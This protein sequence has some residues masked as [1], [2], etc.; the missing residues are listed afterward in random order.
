[1]KTEDHIDAIVAYWH[2]ERPDLD[3]S[4]VEVVG[5]LGRVVEHVDRALDAKFAEFEIS[6]ADW[7]VMAALL[8]VGKPYRM[9]QRDLMR[10]LCRTSG[11]MSLRI[12][13]LVLDGLVTR[14][15]DTDDRRSTFVVLTREGIAKIEAVLP[16]HLANQAR[17][18]HGL[19]ATERAQLA[20][21]LKKWMSALDS[22]AVEAGNLPLGLSVL[23]PRASAS[24]RR[25]VGLPDIP[26]LLIATVEADSLAEKAGLRKGDL[27]TAVDATKIDT[28]GSL[29]RA[30]RRPRP[31]HKH[32]HL[33]RGAEVLLI[34]VQ[35]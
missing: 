18:L 17:L 19:T 11:S 32:V 29:L 31:K 5:R 27:I 24:K 35:S 22:E 26:G 28:I 34:E 7:D 15:Q 1:M 21:L 30:M 14:E 23:T 25:A 6:K 13:A 33:L 8:R 10:K 20:A 9:M 16:E 2:R 4:P 3:V 12:D